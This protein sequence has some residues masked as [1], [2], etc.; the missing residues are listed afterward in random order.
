M[1]SGWD[2]W[3]GFWLAFPLALQIIWCPI[4]QCDSTQPIERTEQIQVG[5]LKR[6]YRLHVPPVHVG[7]KP[8][9]LLLV[10]HGRF[11]D[12]TDIEAIT[13]FSQLAD[14]QGF[15]VV[16][17][18]GIRG[19]WN[20]GRVAM[21]IFGAGNY[22]DVGFVKTLLAHL[23]A[24]LPIDP[25]RVYATG[26]SNGAMFV[27]RLAC[28]LPDTFA[29]IGPVAG[30]LPSNVASQCTSSSPMSVIEFHGTKDA[31]VHWAGGSV[32]VIGG[33][34]L[35]VSDTMAHWRK[36]DGCPETLQVEYLPHRDARV[37]SRMRRETAGQCQGGTATIL[38]VIEGGGHTWPGGPDDS[39]PFMGSVNRDVSASQ[40]IWSF[41]AQHPKTPQTPPVLAAITPQPPAATVLHDTTGSRNVAPQPLRSPSVPRVS[42]HFMFLQVLP[43]G[44]L[45]NANLPFL[46][47]RSV[48]ESA[49]IRD[50]HWKPRLQ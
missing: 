39:T 43:V 35:S 16:Y 21:P 19:H 29:A 46:M 24:T 13:Q 41:F 9:P 40:A 32:R 37:R 36:R 8:L 25:T 45:P 34:T 2:N 23:E 18:A 10:F 17:P 22:D 27:Q 5:E 47:P 14:E 50:E 6:T 26:M 49:P 31:Y 33:K 12:D 44:I 3:A 7:I 48:N 30:T 38:Y 42:P 28:E 20:D 15:I 4:S 1:P 11:E